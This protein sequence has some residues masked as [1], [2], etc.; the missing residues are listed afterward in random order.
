MWFIISAIIFF[1]LLYTVVPYFLSRGLGGKVFK[2]GRDLSKV[3]FTFDD[4]P[5][6]IYTPILLFC[7]QINIKLEDI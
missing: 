7:N 5:N 6:P 2:R 3:A 4:G 1:F